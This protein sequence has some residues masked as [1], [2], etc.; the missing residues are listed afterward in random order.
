MEAFTVEQ[1]IAEQ[2]ADERRYLEFLRKETM[3]LGLYVLPAGGIDPQQ[4]H[5]EDEVYYIISGQGQIDVGDE[6]Q[7]VQPGSVVF[8]AAHVPHKFHTITEELKILVFFAPPESGP[9]N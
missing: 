7:S 5:G 1:L 6:T 8:V 2:A 4:P 3:S 9:T